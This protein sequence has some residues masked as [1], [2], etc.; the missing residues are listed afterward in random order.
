M[1]GRTTAADELRLCPELL[2]L[3]AVGGLPAAGFKVE[4]DAPERDERVPSLACLV[5]TITMVIFTASAQHAAVN[6]PQY[7]VMSYVPNM[8]LAAYQPAPE[9]TGGC[10]EADLLALMPPLDLAHL[11][12]SLGYLLGSIHHTRIGQYPDMGADSSA[13]G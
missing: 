10:S 1:G 2:A 3:E 7:P 5:D 13:G 9:R 11:Q 8:P 12:L 4:V 6:F